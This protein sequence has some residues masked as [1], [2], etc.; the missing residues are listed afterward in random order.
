[1]GLL[2]CNSYLWKSIK[3]SGIEELNKRLDRLLESN[4]A[5]ELLLLVEESLMPLLPG[6]VTYSNMTVLR[7]KAA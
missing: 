1:M 2:F 4:E 5:R 3:A 7:R 6:S